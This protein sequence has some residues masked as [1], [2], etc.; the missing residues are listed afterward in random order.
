VTDPQYVRLEVSEGVGT[1]RLD[2]P[3]MNALDAQVQH[4]LYEAARQ[5][6]D[7]ADVRAVVV[8]GGAKVFAAGAD[9]AEMR[10][11]GYQDVLVRIGGLQAALGSIAEIPKPTVAAVTGYALGGGLEV[12][13]SCDFRV[14]GDNAR[15]GVPEIQLGVIPGGGGTQRLARLI[16]PARAKDM[17]FTGRHVRAAEAFTIGLVDE[18]VA[19]DDVYEVAFQRA[20]RFT[21]GPALALRAAKYAIDQGL[22]STLSVGL[23]IERQ[24]FA[25]LFATEDRTIGMDSFVENGPG[26]AEFVGR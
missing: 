10:G 16:G 18:V 12:A 25:S 8:Y 17:V 24:Q 5:A 2:R 11:W 1:I 22:D 4:E 9:I 3:P 21:T 14:A 19:P 7:R 15:L 20:L 6:A 13:L 26:K 23:A